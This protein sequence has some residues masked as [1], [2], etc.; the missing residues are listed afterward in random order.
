[1]SGSPIDLDVPDE[2]VYQ[3]ML[4]LI[5]SRRRIT[6]NGCWEYTGKVGPRG[7]AGISFRKKR[8]R[9]HR[10]VYRIVKG[11]FPRDYDVMH[12][13]DNPPCFNPDHLRAGT[14]QENVRDCLS[15]NRQFSQRKT[16]CPRGHA[17][18]DNAAWSKRPSGVWRACAI[19]H[20]AKCRRQRGWPEESLFIPPQPIGHNTGLRNKCRPSQLGKD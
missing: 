10:L 16:H 11:P 15:K 18:A 13:C 2:S 9:I 5:M 1:M 14:T 7:Y 12:L 6:A 3:P 19:C 20:R 4:K 17:Y 8:V